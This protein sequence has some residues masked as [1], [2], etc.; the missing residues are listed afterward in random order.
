MIHFQHVLQR[1]VYFLAINLL[2]MGHNIPLHLPFSCLFLLATMLQLPPHS[3][4][5]SLLTDPLDWLPAL[6]NSSENT[7]ILLLATVFYFH[8]KPIKPSAK[9]KNFTLISKM[10]FWKL[11]LLVYYLEVVKIPYTRVFRGLSASSRKMSSII[12]T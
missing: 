10:L 12:K 2:L 6:I 5:T 8:N 4:P 3:H 11:S 9:N 7:F 1:A